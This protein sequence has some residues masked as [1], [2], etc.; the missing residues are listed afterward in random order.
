ME[1]GFCRKPLALKLELARFIEGAPKQVAS[2]MTRLIE[3]AGKAKH[4][5]VISH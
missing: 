2:T 3:E 5:L 4:I 1:E